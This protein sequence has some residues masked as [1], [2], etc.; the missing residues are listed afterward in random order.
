MPGFHQLES[1]PL[2]LPP[3][4]GG[5]LNFSAK[6]LSLRSVTSEKLGVDRDGIRSP[7]CFIFRRRT[8][9]LLP[10]PISIRFDR[11]LGSSHRTGLARG[12][13]KRNA[14]SFSPLG[15]AKCGGFCGQGRNRTADT[16]I[17]S[18]LLY[19]LSYLSENFQTYRARMGEAKY[20]EVF[21]IP[22]LSDGIRIPTPQEFGRHACPK[23]GQALVP[24]TIGPP[25]SAVSGLRFYKNTT[26]SAKNQPHTRGIALAAQPKT[27]FLLMMSRAITIF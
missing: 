8:A 16:W 10:R 12:T 20:V 17:F 7:P 27:P 15:F 4:N 2:A 18:P 21:R 22:S 25:P 6:L 11:P 14:L 3:N 19:H 24:M 9:D 5:I 1:F 13:K 23:H 26:E